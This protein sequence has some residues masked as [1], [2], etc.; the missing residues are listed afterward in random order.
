MP[1]TLLSA[2]YAMW[3]KIRY[4]LSSRSFQIQVR[5]ILIRESCTLM[6]RYIIKGYEGRLPKEPM[7]VLRSEGRLVFD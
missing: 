2:R 1:G 4:T 5:Q 6:L 7:I 3:G